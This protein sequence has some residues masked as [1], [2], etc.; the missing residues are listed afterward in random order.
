L[1]RSGWEEIPPNKNFVH[2]LNANIVLLGIALPF[3]EVWRKERL[4]SCFKNSIDCP[5]QSKGNYNVNN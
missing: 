4:P 2:F 3:L 1:P 5:S